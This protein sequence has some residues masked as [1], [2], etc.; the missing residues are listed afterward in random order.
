MYTPFILIFS[1]FTALAEGPEPDPVPPTE[2]AWFLSSSAF[3]LGNLLPE[4]PRFVQLN[5]GYRFNEKNTLILEAITWTYHA[6]LGIP[7]GPD[8]VDPA[9]RFP[10]H[11]R[12]LGVGL[13]YQRYW[14]KGAYTTAH[15]TPFRQTYFDEQGERIQAG[16]QL[17]TVLRAGYHFSFWKERL[18]VEPSV[19]VTSWPVNTNLP[20]GFAEQESQWR[21][22]FLGEPGLHFGVNF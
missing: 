17:F 22:F 3:M 10:G 15:I 14:W 8:L 19:A 13:A 1:A 11:V 21:S 6:P 5:V 12:D 20:A 4:P 2:G 9:N 7:Y 18:F 16:F